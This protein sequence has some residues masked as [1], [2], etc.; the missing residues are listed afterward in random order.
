MVE[1][2]DP[3]GV[4]FLDLN[5]EGLF[6]LERFCWRQDFRCEA[7]WNQTDAVTSAHGRVRRRVAQADEVLDDPGIA[8]VWIGPQISAEIAVS[9]LQRGKSLLM[10]IPVGWSSA[11][12]KSV[13]GAVADAPSRIF[14]AALHR[15]DGP[16]RTMAQ[17]CDSGQLGILTEIRRI[18]WQYVPQEL[19]AAGHSEPVAAEV[20]DRRKWF[21]WIDELLLL[22]GDDVTDVSVGAPAAT[23][24]R[25]AKGLAVQVQ[26]DG[27]CTARLELNRQSLAP[28]ETGW[29]VN[30]TLA[31]LAD[32]KRFTPGAD[33]EL[34]DVPVV[35]LP[36]DHEA[37]YDA[38][39]ESV[40][41]RKTFPV[42][43]TTVGR[44]LE[45][46]DRIDSRR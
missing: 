42:S 26:F 17:I 35:E 1:T 11:A 16:F 27:G 29:V 10:G 21:Q 31:G 30:G 45:V 8:L 33:Y 38:L 18:S 36:S 15:W 20:A 43:T 2:M 34:V 39:A 32:G 9:A 24:A 5:P 3:I 28:I 23:E 40:L 19:G 22:V 6:H 44:V 13:C 37:F 4:G 25:D 46:L 41:S 12:W 7:L 14:V